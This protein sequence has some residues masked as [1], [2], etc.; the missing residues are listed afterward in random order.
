MVVPMF[1]RA[2]EFAL[3]IIG[4]EKDPFSDQDMDVA[5]AFA[6]QAMVAL[7]NARLFAEV[8]NLAT[9]DSLTRLH[10]RRY[11][12]ELSELEFTRSRRYS[13]ELSILL[14]DADHFKDVNDTF[15]HEVGDRVLKIIANIC[16]TNLRH[17]DIVGRYGGEEFI[18]R[19][20][21]D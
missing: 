19:F 9:T 6:K 18:V 5:S 7:E 10:N 13:R 1:S 16:R 14:L 3:L 2:E 21:P 11:F 12:L 17:F 15:G 4:R 20:D 8:Q